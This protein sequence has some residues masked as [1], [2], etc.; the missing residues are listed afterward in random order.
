MCS[1]YDVVGVCDYDG[2]SGY[3]GVGV[4]VHDCGSGYDIVGGCVYGGGS[5]NDDVGGCGFLF[6]ISSTYKSSVYLKQCC[7]MTFD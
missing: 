5:G 1:G 3:D 6:F 4:C 7:N 2:S